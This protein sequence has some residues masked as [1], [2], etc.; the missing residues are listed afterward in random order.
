MKIP[1]LPRRPARHRDHLR[2]CA[3]Q[4][5]GTCRQ[6]HRQGAGGVQWRRSRGDC[7]RRALRPSG[8]EAREHRHVR[9]Q[10]CDLRGPHR[11]HE[12]VQRAVRPR[13]S[14][15]R[16]PKRWSEPMSSS[17]FR[18]TAQ[19][20]RTWCVSMAPNPDHLRPGQSRSGD[21]LRGGQGRRERRHHGHRTVRL[22]Q[23][24]Q[25]RARLP[26]HLPRGAGRARHDDQ[27]QR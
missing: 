8:R 13:P 21:Q 27:R 20:R 4:C 2:R 24:G 3:A 11:G 18:S 23:P 25:Q 17:G 19:S 16:W 9:H 15:A 14:R 10:G 5:A 22:S 26:V 7:L 1:G 6:G 12:P